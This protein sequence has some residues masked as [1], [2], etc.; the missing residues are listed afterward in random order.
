MVE[1]SKVVDL[2]PRAD[3]PYRHI[4]L[5]VDREGNPA[6]GRAVQLGQNNAIYRDALEKTLGL[7]N[8]ILPRCRIQ[9]EER[10]DTS[11]WTGLDRNP[12]YLLQLLHKVEL[13]MEP[14]GGVDQNQI[15]AARLP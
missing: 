12:P 1:W 5:V 2:L 6:L 9:N 4:E 3:K 7:Q 15:D 14:P 13:G 11:I 10:N 8:C